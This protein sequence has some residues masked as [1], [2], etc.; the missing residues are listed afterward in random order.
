MELQGVDW[1]LAAMQL[2]LTVKKCHLAGALSQES[3]ENFG[4]NFPHNSH[5]KA[6]ITL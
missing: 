5:K 3:E 2:E 6:Y 4:I 1:S